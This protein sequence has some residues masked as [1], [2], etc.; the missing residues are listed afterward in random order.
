MRCV[1]H[2]NGNTDGVLCFH[3]LLFSFFRFSWISFC[4][5]S[6]FHSFCV[7]RL[8]LSRLFICWSHAN[9][10]HWDHIYR[11][12]GKPWN[13]QTRL[14]DYMYTTIYYTCNF[15]LI[16]SSFSSSSLVFILVW[17]FLRC[18]RS[19]Y[20]NLMFQCVCVCVCA[21]VCLRTERERNRA[22]Y[23]S[24]IWYSVCWTAFDAF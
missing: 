10:A 3:L 5:F 18:Y 13:V 7:R 17:I 12:I 1:Y 19:I 11:S 6:F 15:F 22:N 24:N 20:R 9:V 4:F 14:C 21:C 8:F 23:L 2:C 16:P